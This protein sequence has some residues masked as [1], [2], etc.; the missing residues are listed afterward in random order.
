MRAAT[1]G[2]GALL[3]IAFLGSDED[4]MGL[5]FAQLL[6]VSVLPPLAAAWTEG[7]WRLRVAHV[8]RKAHLQAAAIKAA[9]EHHQDDEDDD[10]TL[11]AD[12]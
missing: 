8:E 11:A 10:D 7:W 6:A 12:A 3:A 1:W 2:V 5:S 9:I 4:G